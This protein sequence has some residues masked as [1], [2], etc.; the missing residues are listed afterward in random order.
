MRLIRL[1][2]G[3]WLTTAAFLMVCAD[4]GDYTKFVHPMITEVA[5]WAK[6]K[7]DADKLAGFLA[8]SDDELRACVPYQSPRIYSLCPNCSKKEN[9]R[10]FRRRHYPNGVFG[11]DPKQPNRIVCTTCKETFPDNPKFPQDKSRKFRAPRMWAD[12]NENA[13]YVIRW[14]EQERESREPEKLKPGQDLS[15]IHI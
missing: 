2:C 6:E 4:D 8:L 14:H 9:G 1:T 3:I 7:P 10:D 13:D 12:L 11:F 15:L 5:N